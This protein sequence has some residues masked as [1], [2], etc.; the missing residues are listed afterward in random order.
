MRRLVPS[1]FD[2][3]AI[4]RLLPT[5]IAA[6]MFAVL[7]LFPPRSVADWPPYL[8]SLCIP[9]C[10]GV[11]SRSPRMSVLGTDLTCVALAVFFPKYD[12]GFSFIAVSI[13]IVT[14]AT[15]GKRRLC[16]A[17]IVAF[18]G[19]A[20]WMETAGEPWSWRSAIGLAFPW[21]FVAAAAFVLGVSLHFQEVHSAL[22]AQQE[23]F[24]TMI[25]MAQ[26]LHDT[27]AN[28]LAAGYLLVEDAI[29]IVELRYDASDPTCTELTSTL[30]SA[31]GLLSRAAAEMRDLV[32]TL[33]SGDL[34]T[35]RL[36]SKELSRALSDAERQLVQAGFAPACSVEDLSPD[37]AAAKVLVNATSEASRNII[38]YGNPGPCTIQLSLDC[39]GRV[40]LTM[41]NAMTEA[42]RPAALLGGNGVAVISQ[43]AQLLGG[44]VT[45]GVAEDDPGMWTFVVEV[46][47]K[48]ERIRK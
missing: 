2:S 40:T 8:L 33:R 1:S 44:T 36:A 20:V 25:S 28:S 10:A 41:S 13:P 32:V 6:V 22:V 39:R 34:D 15:M 12:V 30:H 19:L 37:P 16:L 35:S 26:A 27:A 11:A 48:D 5:G 46:P 3:P 42:A 45:A 14:L 9:L 31:S 21:I 47:M 17:Q 38:K 43:Q 29:Q 23:V 7:V 18:I 4:T 24:K